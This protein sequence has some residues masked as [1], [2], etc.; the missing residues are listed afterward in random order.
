MSDSTNALVID[1][2]IVRRDSIPL[3]IPRGYVL[4]KTLWA[5]WGGVDE[6]VRRGLVPISK[7]VAGYTGVGVVVETG[8]DA[9]ASLAGKTVSLVEV[10][11]EYMPPIRGRGFLAYYT[12]APSSQLVSVSRSLCNVLLLDSSLACETLSIIEENEPHNVLITG[13]GVYGIITA[14]LLH[15][16]GIEYNI[17]MTRSKDTYSLIRDLGLSTV[18]TIVETDALVDATLDTFLVERA[19][20]ETKAWL[21]IMHPLSAYRGL[22]ISPFGQKMSIIGVRGRRDLAGCAER[23]A[24]KVWKSLANHISFIDGLVAPPEKG[25]PHLGVVYKL[26]S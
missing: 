4:I 10:S 24:K 2:G 21:L 18:Q 19:L 16:M 7:S 17:L 1:G 20:R 9:D 23:V 13:L 22:H 14:H 6:A 8:I 12:A 25:L 26:S 11:R 5:R 3:I 15:D